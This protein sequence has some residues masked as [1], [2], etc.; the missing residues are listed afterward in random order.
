MGVEVGR[1]SVGGKGE[2]EKS[3]LEMAEAL[4]KMERSVKSDEADLL[5]E[6]LPKLKAGKTLKPK[7]AG[8]L[9]AMY[10]KYLGEKEEDKPLPA[11]EEEEDIDPDDFQ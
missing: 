10:E 6:V 1:E 3:H 5:E 4:D 8:A 11:D 2:M 9:K 7:H